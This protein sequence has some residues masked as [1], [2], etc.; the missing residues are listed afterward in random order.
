MSN[1][2]HTLEGRVAIVTGAGRGIGRA[3]ALAL[4]ARGASV[5]VNDLGVT[6]RGEMGEQGLAESVVQEIA[7]MGGQAV[8]NCDSVSEWEGAQRIVE[9]ALDHFGGL[10]LL[11]NNAGLSVSVSD[12]GNRARL[13]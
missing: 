13:V 3:T 1:R 12:L 5:V 6:L 10:D 8:A 11:V 4:S 9:T 2:S 7:A